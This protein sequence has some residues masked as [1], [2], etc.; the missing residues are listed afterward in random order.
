VKQQALCIKSDEDQMQIYMKLIVLLII[1]TIL[2]LGIIIGRGISSELDLATWTGALATVAIALLTFVLAAETW[3]LRSIQIAQIEEIRKDSIRPLIEIFIEQ[4][5]SHFQI[6]NFKV[7]N[8][9]KGIAKNVSFNLIERDD[10]LSESEEYLLS[11]LNSMSFFKRKISVLGL[12]KSRSSFLFS[13]NEIRENHP[14]E[15][16]FEACLSFE[17]V[18]YNSEGVR[19]TAYSVIDL[20]EFEGITQVGKDPVQ[21]VYSELKDIN[22]N[23]LSI[24][25][26]KRLNINLHIPTIEELKGKSRIDTKVA[27]YLGIKMPWYKSLKSVLI[28]KL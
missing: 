19:Y 16:L 10:A 8:V 13:F 27:D 14:N 26:N 20:S 24:T 1:P 18:F 25:K 6:F 7:E 11:K 28:S 17:I 15:E 9:G 3:R 23:I 12:G 2:V 21:G 22:K 4:S 5:P